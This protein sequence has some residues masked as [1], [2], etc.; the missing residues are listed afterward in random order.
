MYVNE[1]LDNTIAEGMHVWIFCSYNFFLYRKV[2]K[3][4]IVRA[5]NS[6]KVLPV[7]VHVYNFVA[8]CRKLNTGK[9]KTV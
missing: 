7:N 2:L 1:G 8:A 9:F 4:H 5:F 6:L 3:T